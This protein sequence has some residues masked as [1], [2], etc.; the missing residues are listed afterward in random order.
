MKLATRYASPPGLSEV[1]QSAKNLRVPAVFVL[2]PSPRQAEPSTA[3]QEEIKKLKSKLKRAERLNNARLAKLEQSMASLVK[4]AHA[5][6]RIERV[7]TPKHHIVVTS[8]NVYVA[9]GLDLS[10]Y[11][12]VK[13]PWYQRLKRWAMKE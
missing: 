5:K 3:D 12:K 2:P 1:E 6:D 10:A 9:D 13:L 11:A 8:S 4:L 7:T